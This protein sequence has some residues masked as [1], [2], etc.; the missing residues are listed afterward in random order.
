M[1]RTS[2]PSAGLSD[3]VRAAAFMVLACMGFSVNDAF[4]KS[5]AGEVPLLQA[6][7]LRGLICTLLIGALAWWAGALRSRPGGATAS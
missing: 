2:A 3:N 5:L 7:F 6:V 1:A 4:M